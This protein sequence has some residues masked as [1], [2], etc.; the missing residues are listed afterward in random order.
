MIDEDAA[1]RA[2]RET[3]YGPGPTP[4]DRESALTVEE[5][6]DFRANA[7]ERLGFMPQEVDRICNAA[8]DSLRR[9]LQQA[10]RV[11]PPSPD[12]E[13]VES[14]IQRLRA[15]DIH[16]DDREPIADAL[17]QLQRNLCKHM[18]RTHRADG[19][20]Y[21][22]DCG[23]LVGVSEREQKQEAD[24]RASERITSLEQQVERLVK[25]LKHAQAIIDDLKAWREAWLTRPHKS[26]PGMRARIRELATGR[27]DFDRAVIMLL[28]DFEAEEKARAQNA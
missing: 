15:G 5:I 10:P 27:D 17:D 19:S 22:L 26:T 3:Q 9:S 24:A 7:H 13:S 18:R 12:R 20:F 6:E 4:G 2:Q 1:L 11:A 28:D 23:K 16:D 21:C 8:L 14:F 25:E